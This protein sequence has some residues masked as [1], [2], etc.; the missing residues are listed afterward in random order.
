M[1]LPAGQR[2]AAFDAIWPA[3]ASDAAV[4]KAIDELYSRSRVLDLVERQKMAKESPGQLR[5]RQ[6]PLLNLGFALEEQLSAM[7]EADERWKGAVSRLRPAWRRA[8]MAHAG[9]P[10]APDAN[11][12]LRVSFAHVKGYSPR[13]AVWYLPF[14]TLAGVIEKHTGEEPFDAPERVR[15]AAAR[16]QGPAPE[17]ANARWRDAVLKDVAVDFLATGDTTGGNSGSPVVN[18]YGELVGLNFDR[19]WENVA[20][21]FG[22][23]PAI[24]RNVSV[25]TRYLL[26][27][28]SQVDQASELL[29]ELGIAPYRQ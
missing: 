4:L 18:G 2:I 6:D 15:Q 8:A 13:D 7:R 1:A 11:S 27:T 19:V 9:K 22:Y 10:I 28:L 3:G 29:A 5:E 16:A 14:T 20:N 24:A 25:D 26:W 21:D 12:T 23:N 17:A